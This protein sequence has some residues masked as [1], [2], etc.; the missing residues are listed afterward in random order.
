MS[1]S[2][3]A[4]AYLCFACPCKNAADGKNASHLGELGLDIGECGNMTQLA[5]KGV[6]NRASRSNDCTGYRYIHRFCHD[7]VVEL[8][9]LFNLI[10]FLQELVLNCQ[11]Q[12][13]EQKR[14][15]KY[16]KLLSILVRVD[17]GAPVTELIIDFTD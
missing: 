8:M 14:S 9:R 1:P 2:I 15:G 13:L 5:I 17:T 3:A 12:D 6:R 10:F 4:L 7:V 16:L 11:I